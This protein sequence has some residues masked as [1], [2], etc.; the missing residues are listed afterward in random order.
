MGLTSQRTN[1][2]IDHATSDIHKATMTESKVEHS[3][4]RA[5]SALRYVNNDRAF[6]VIDGRRNTRKDGKQ[7]RCVLHDGEREL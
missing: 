6:F 2:F 1:N 3:R 5:E 4:A 7:V